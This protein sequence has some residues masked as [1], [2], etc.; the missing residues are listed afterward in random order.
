MQNCTVLGTLK[1]FASYYTSTLSSLPVVAL[2]A[3]SFKRQSSIDPYDSCLFPC[4]RTHS[5]ILGNKTP[6]LEND[7]QQRWTDSTTTSN[8]LQ[9]QSQSTLHEGLLSQLCTALGSVKVKAIWRALESFC[10]LQQFWVLALVH[11]SNIFER[12]KNKIS[13]RS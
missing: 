8:C 9:L 2:N 3:S 5:C 12:T 11:N 6:L 13:D 1:V 10:W 4:L 7:L